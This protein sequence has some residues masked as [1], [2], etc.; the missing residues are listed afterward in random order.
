M[1][2][3]NN[4][5]ARVFIHS[6]MK[7]YKN[8]KD[9]NRLYSSDDFIPENIIN[10]YYSYVL[11][12]EFSFV[13]NEYKKQFVFNEARVEPNVSKEEMTGLGMVYDYIQE[14]N[15][16]K[17][18][19]NIFITSLILHQ[20]LYSKC[21]NPQF[22]GTLR[23]CNVVLYDL[24]VDV[25]NAQEAIKLFN[26]YIATSNNIFEPLKAGDIFQYIDNTV[27][28]TTDLIHLQPFLDGNKR[29]FRA[30]QNLLLKKIS[31]PP[32]YIEVNERDEYK[33]NLLI[34]ISKR[35]Y[36]PLIRFY[37]YKICDAIMNLDIEK[38]EIFDNS[39]QKIKSLH[40]LP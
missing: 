12:P 25:P 39:H 40:K 29:T 19:F 24:P 18:N 28:L 13:I 37:Y 8:R 34:A 32:V 9:Q 14:F 7:G 5:E 2:E 21:P 6:M 27:I 23:D 26:Q 16:D 4:D 33:K 20:K 30:L 36:S 11:K 3:M 15:F 17:D 22:G 31:F 10:T 1:A 38:S 35:N